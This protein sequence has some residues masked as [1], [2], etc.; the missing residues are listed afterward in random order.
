MFSRV[1]ANCILFY[2]RGRR[3]LVFNKWECSCYVYQE[4]LNSVAYSLSEFVGNKKW[5]VQVWKSFI[6]A[7][8]RPDG[9]KDTSNVNSSTAHQS[10]GEMQKQLIQK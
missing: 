9:N 3:V 1:S 7:Y 4:S 5:Q 8:T 6:S 10:I 2:L